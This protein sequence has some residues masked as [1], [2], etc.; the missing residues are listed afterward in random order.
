V[1][2]LLLPPACV[3][4]AVGLRAPGNES[5]LEGRGLVSALRRELWPRQTTI[6]V[7][8]LSCQCHSST[9]SPLSPLA[10]LQIMIVH[11]TSATACSQPVHNKTGAYVAAVVLLVVSS[12]IVYYSSSR[13]QH[14]SSAL[15]APGR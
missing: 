3:E 7:A 2:G 1:F 5:L 10:A 9:V 6:K 8:L 14:Y 11:N 12:C 13:F 15:E 4:T